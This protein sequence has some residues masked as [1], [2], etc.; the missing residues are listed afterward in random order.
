MP[1]PQRRSRPSCMAPVMPELLR[2]NPG[3]GKGLELSGLEGPFQAKPSHS[4]GLRT[5]RDAVVLRIVTRQ[6]C[7]GWKC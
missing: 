5:Q 1:Q 3:R 2:G 7:W 4:V 6:V